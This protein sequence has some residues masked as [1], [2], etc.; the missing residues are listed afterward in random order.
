MIVTISF[1]AEGKPRRGD[2]AA[3]EAK[4][5]EDEARG[6]I[7]PGCGGNGRRRPGEGAEKDP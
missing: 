7:A 5:H 1:E 6:A 3:N 2:S 4:A